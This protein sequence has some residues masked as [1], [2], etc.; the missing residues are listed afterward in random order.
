M[1]LQLEQLQ[2]RGS[3]VRVQLRQVLPRELLVLGQLEQLQQRGP[4]VLE[5][6]RPLTLP[7][8]QS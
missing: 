8:L 7:P 6:L 4:L 1:L 5:Q 2:L 3:L